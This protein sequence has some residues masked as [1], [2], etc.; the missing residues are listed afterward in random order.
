MLVAPS[1]VCYSWPKVVQVMFQGAQLTGTMGT[2][3]GSTNG[4]LTALPTK[5]KPPL[6]VAEQSSRRQFKGRNITVSWVSR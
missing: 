6:Q 4:P 2:L 3:W 5:T 1:R